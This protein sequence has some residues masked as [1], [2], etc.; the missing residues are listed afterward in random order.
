M[1]NNYER[2]I[3]GIIHEYTPQIREDQITPNARLV[4]DLGLDSLD[5]LDVIMSVETACGVNISDDQLKYDMKVSDL[6][7]IV[8]EPKIREGRELMYKRMLKQLA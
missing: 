8:R 2:I 7:Q 1:T 5:L 3:Q 4:H 6:Y